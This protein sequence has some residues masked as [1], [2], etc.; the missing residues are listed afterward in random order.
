MV[1]H[2]FQK[3]NYNHIELA[4]STITTIWNSTL[5]HCG[6][7]SAILQGINDRGQHCLDQIQQHNLLFSSQ[8]F[9]RL[10]ALRCSPSREFLDDEDINN[11]YHILT[12]GC[13]I[14]D[15]S[16]IKLVKAG[17]ATQDED[18]VTFNSPMAFN[19]ARDFLFRSPQTRN[20]VNFKTLEELMEFFFSNISLDNMTQSI[21]T[22]S[23][24]E[25]SEDFF[26]K[27]FY[28]I[29]TSII[30]PEIHLNSEISKVEGS[31]LKGRVDFYLNTTLNW[32]IELLINGYQGKGRKNSL[33]KHSE[34]F[35]EN[36]S[37]YNLLLQGICK[38]YIVVDISSSELERY[39]FDRR[40]RF[41]ANTWVVIY[42]LNDNEPLF[43]IHKYND[44]G[45]NHEIK[46]IPIV[47][48]VRNLFS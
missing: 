48:I 18:F 45:V 46:I 32:G 15:K 10:K 25:L 13:I 27:E 34:R 39:D 5:G 7:V 24:G 26:Q 20:G 1:I 31:I 28:R 16:S 42:T 2:D 38:D 40:N 11:F 29:V 35:L 12:D 8:T 23:K 4:E 6:Y 14:L 41:Y 17:V 37:Y 44:K 19:I 22:G 30:P 33:Y 43:T 3:R 36:G 47:P 21:S 9:D